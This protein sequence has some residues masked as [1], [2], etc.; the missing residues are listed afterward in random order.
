MILIANIVIKVC[1]SNCSI[2]YHHP[3]EPRDE[4]PAHD[5]DTVVRMVRMKNSHGD[6]AP[7][8]L[9]VDA[10][11]DD[12]VQHS[13]EVRV[14]EDMTRLPAEKAAYDSEIAAWLEICASESGNG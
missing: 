11:M 7:G 6:G 12:F 5:D 13:E 4:G 14:I 1:T 9:W 2:L 3:E 8:D 10:T